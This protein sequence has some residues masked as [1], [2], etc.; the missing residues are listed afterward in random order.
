[1]TKNI[2]YSESSLPGCG[3]P[4]PRPGARPGAG[5]NGERLVIGPLSM[6]LGQAQPKKVAWEPLPRGSPPAGGAKLGQVQ[7]VLGSSRRQGP[8]RSYHELQKLALGTWNVTSLMGKEPVLV[9]KVEKFWLDIVSLTSTHG[10]GSW[11]SLLERGWNLYHS[12]FAESEIWRAILV[13][14]PCSV[15]IHWSYPGERESSLPLP[16]GGGTD[17]DCFLCLWP[18]HQLSVSTPFGVLRGGTG[19]FPLLGYPSSSWLTS[20]VT[21]LCS[22]WIIHNK[23][24]A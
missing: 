22:S 14:P 8:W 7:E 18:K 17:T 3:L 2:F 13:A 21:F 23:H 5:H 19:K 20:M 24:Q 11:T 1:M 16:L 15:P 6:G 9:R 12:G 10:N 4:E